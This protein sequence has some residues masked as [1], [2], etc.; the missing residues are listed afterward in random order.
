ML[1]WSIYVTVNMN[2][3][4]FQRLMKSIDACS[5]MHVITAKLTISKNYIKYLNTIPHKYSFTNITLQ[6]A[7]HQRIK[8][9]ISL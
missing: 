4:N 6:T 3:Y 2:F 1:E 9:A 8:N 5:N 7:Q